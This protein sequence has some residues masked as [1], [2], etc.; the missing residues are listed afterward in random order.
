MSTA[1]ALRTEPT[2]VVQHEA[3]SFPE[4][5]SMGQQLVGTGFM[6]E[7]IKNGAQAAAIILAGRELGMPPMR[8]L[9]SLVLV[10]GKVTE[11]A[12]SQLS[13]FKSDGG[14][15]VFR[16]LTETSA[17]LWIKHPN[18]DEHV[19]SF[20]MQDAQ[21]AG[22]T[23]H[24]YSKFPKA[25]LRSRVITAALKSVGWE[26][27]AGVYDP[28]ELAE[29]V[30]VER[31]TTRAQVEDAQ[32]V[33]SEPAPSTKQAALLEK[34][35]RSHVFTDTEREKITRR[36]SSA[37]KMTAAID[38]VQEQIVERKAAEKA[39]KADA[40]DETEQALD[41]IYDAAKDAAAA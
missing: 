18:G 7:H 25:M 28:S 24:M 6:P 32:I 36:A 10:K 33:E 27:G 38:Y 13:R 22:I 12:D 5:V 11:Y 14:R 41:A 15:A 2:A 34:L 1:L 8:A 37:A 20:T 3:A 29:P 23:G 31:E 35:L 16:E 26:G 17:V 39:A 19:E 40:P 4:L 30:V 21:K 9:R